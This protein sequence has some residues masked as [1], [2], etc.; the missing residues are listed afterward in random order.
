MYKRITHKKIIGVIS[1]RERAKGMSTQPS[2][3]WLR[4]GW[5]VRESS[6]GNMGLD[7]G[8]RI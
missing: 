5:L 3:R 6:L 4:A 2:L 1:S 7:L 8:Y